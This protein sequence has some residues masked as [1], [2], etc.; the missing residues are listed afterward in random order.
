MPSFARYEQESRRKH[1]R[2]ANVADG[3]DLHFR[4]SARHC[5]R[6]NDRTVMRSCFFGWL[7]H[8]R[9]R[10][11]AIEAS[12]YDAR[13]VSGNDAFCEVM[14]YQE[15]YEYDL[16]VAL[17]RSWDDV[18]WDLTPLGP[19]LWLRRA[20]IAGGFATHDLLQSALQP[21]AHQISRTYSIIVM[22]GHV[23]NA[24]NSQGPAGTLSNFVQAF[25][26]EPLPGQA[27]EEAWLW[28]PNPKSRGQITP[29]DDRPRQSRSRL[30]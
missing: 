18:S 21:V 4:Q 28:A 25:R 29:P 22:N 20:W 26:L 2:I 24:V 9:S 1:P 12:L 23:I 8:E 10:I 7:V 27:G 3:L 14:D 19:I 16:G 15:L 17:C 5:I 11:G 13:P 30:F 6:P